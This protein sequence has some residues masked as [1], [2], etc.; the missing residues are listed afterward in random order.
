[1]QIIESTTDRIAELAT[2]LRDASRRLT[3]ASNEGKQVILHQIRQIKRDIRR[4]SAR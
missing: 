2:E 4:N 1:M 3:D